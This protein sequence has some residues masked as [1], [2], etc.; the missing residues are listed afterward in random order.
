MFGPLTAPEGVGEFADAF[1]NSTN[2]AR[3]PSVTLDQAGGGL[4]TTAHD[5]GKLMRSLEGGDPVGLDVLGSDWTED[6]MSRGLDYGYGTWRWRPRRIF[7]A[8]WRVPHLIGVSGSTNSFA[9][10]TAK[11]D[12][13]TGT[14][15]QTDDPS[16][17]V[18]CVLSKVLPVLGRVK[19]R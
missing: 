12:V 16:R 7:F 11:G 15:D 10:R 19:E 14:L 5:L 17:H 4:A 13:L 18:K 2:L 3:S 9:Y 1:A 6:A 8:F